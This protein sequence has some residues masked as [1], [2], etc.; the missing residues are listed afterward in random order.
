MQLSPVDKVPVSFPLTGEDETG[1]PIALTSVV[2]A[3][4]PF[5]SAPAASTAW[6]PAAYVNGR[7]SLTIAGPDADPTG[8]VQVPA[9]GAYLWAKDTESA[10]VQAVRVDFISIG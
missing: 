6:S 8:A 2:V 1:S 3:L 7:V 4:L 9:G 10:T 5:R